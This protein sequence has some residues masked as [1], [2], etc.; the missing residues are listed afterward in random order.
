MGLLGDETVLDAGCGAGALTTQL[1]AR[2]PRGRVVA[3]DT[4]PE[5]LEAARRVLPVK[6]VDLLVQ[7]LTSLVL[8]D[9][10]DAVASMGTFHLIADHDALVGR[11]AAALRPGGRLAARCAGAGNVA[12]VHAAVERLRGHE[13]WA[14]A[15]T[16]W[17]SPWTFATPEE[18][19]ARL[20][21]AGFVDVDCRLDAREVVPDDPYAHLRT[22]VL[23]RHLERLPEEA[24]DDFVR[25][26]QAEM[27]AAEG[28]VVL[29]YVGLEI[30]ATKAPDHRPGEHPDEIAARLRG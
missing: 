11:L 13:P 21:A 23:G 4:S 6:L 12:A 26:V 8:E 19:A 10:V 9:P 24:H 7:D 22:V 1:L 17:A 30:D 3:V 20:T 18:T 27:Q 15:L 5:A 28:A 25:A 16:G 14:T 29:R 2:V